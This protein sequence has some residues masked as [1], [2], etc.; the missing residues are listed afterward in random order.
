MT[1]DQL[2]EL[3]SGLCATLS[4]IGE[5]DAAL[6]LGRFALLAMVRLGDAD[7]ARQLIDEAAAGLPGH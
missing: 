3:Y 6:F 4:K 7:L 1:T 5:A 2:D